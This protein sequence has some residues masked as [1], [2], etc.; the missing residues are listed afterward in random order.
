MEQSSTAFN[1]Q[2]SEKK[3]YERLLSVD[4]VR[5][6]AIFGVLFIHP[7]IFGTWYTETLALEIVPIYVIAIFAPIILMGTWGG[8][9]P[10]ISAVVNTYNIYHRLEIGYSYKEAAKPVIINSTFI[11]LISPI[12]NLLF[13]RTWTN[14][15]QE[16]M[17][18]SIL[19]RLMEEGELAWPGPEKI[20]QIGSLPSIAISGYITVLILWILFKNE[21][22]NKVKRNAIILTIIG[23]FLTFISNPLNELL[24]PIII[25]LFL[26]GRISRFFAF[27]LRWFFGA[28]LS[29]FPVGIYGFFG[30]VAGI[31]LSVRAPLKKIK[32]YGYG[33]GLFYLAAFII[34]LIITTNKALAQGKNP[35]FVIL[36]YEVYPRE[37]L[38]FSLGCMLILL[39]FMVKRYEYIPQELKVK[40]AKKSLF[41]R[42]F[43]VATLTFYVL[44][45]I[46]NNSFALLFHTIFGPR[47]G[48]GIQD[49]FMTNFWAIL[50]YV[51]T[52]ESFWIL[53]SYFWSKTGYKY[54]VEYWI[55]RISNRFRE[56][57]STRLQLFD[58]QQ[59][60]EPILENAKE[61]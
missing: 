52:F 55:I 9:F 30:I 14:S 32:R 42:R 24:N 16:G 19:S 20:F 13:S 60:K 12:K 34:S 57:K 58:Y 54:G 17:N 33:L 39:V 23:I 38:F 29:Y 1:I 28:Q 11:L 10:L 46:F 53:F 26:K 49:P 48:F 41:F 37:L 40:R 15:Y 5:G 31:F 18:Y 45:P 6:I 43:G 56:T 25:D 59:N 3:K 35:I 2:K 50:L 8:G 36:D 21:G 7:M 22:R 61:K 27:I 47:E 51:F 44:E 4:I